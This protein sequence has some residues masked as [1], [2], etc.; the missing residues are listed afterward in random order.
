MRNLRNRT[1]KAFAGAAAAA[2][3]ACA[4]G[5]P[6]GESIASAQTAI[7][8]AE[9][10][11]TSDR[12]AVTLRRAEDKLAKAKQEAESGDAD[13]ARRLAAEAEVEAELAGALA[14]QS[15]ADAILAEVQQGVDDLRD[16]L[17]VEE[18]DEQQATGEQP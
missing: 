13:R 12:A 6:P 11:A 17:R 3:L 16:E 2:S 4:S 15:R 7:R 18:R 5:P 1:C 9:R 10:Q 14:Q 8:N